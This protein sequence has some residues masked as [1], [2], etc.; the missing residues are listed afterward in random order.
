MNKK[1]IASAIAGLGLIASGS[2]SA[3]VV[4]GVD[5]GDTGLVSHIETTSLAETIVNDNNQELFG[6]G[7]ISMVNGLSSYAGGSKLYFVFDSYISNDVTTAT[8]DFSGGAIRVYLKPEFNLLNFSS[9]SNFTSIDTGT[10][11]LTL[12]GHTLFPGNATGPDTLRSTGEIVGEAISFKGSGLLDVTGGLA[13]VVAF[14]DSNTRPDGAGGF[15]DILIN[16]SGSNDGL[17]A[18][19]DTSACTRGGTPGTRATNWC[20]AGSADLRGATVVPEPGVLALLGMGLLGM[21]VSLRKR[22]SA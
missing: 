5:F 21:G 3:I 4:G 9:E 1:L 7:V 16:T 17:N 2:A 11:W 13:D 18:K 6:Y 19:D 10:P 12:A 15:A 14:L 20:V 22:K 8:A